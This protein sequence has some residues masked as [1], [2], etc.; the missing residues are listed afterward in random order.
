MDTPL[1]ANEDPAQAQP[2]RWSAVAGI[3]GFL[4]IVELTSGIL[5]GYY[6]PLMTDIARHLGIHDADVNWFEAAQLMVSALA[7]PLLAS[8]GDIFGHKKMLLLSAVV[9]AI[10][11]WAVVFS[12]SF[13]TFLIAWAFQG[14]YAVW[15]PLEIAIV[16]SRARKLGVPGPMTRR[17]AG[18]LVGALEF[19][20]IGGAL[21][22]GALIGVFDGNIA[23]TM[24]I[25][26]VATTACIFAVAFGVPDDGDRNGAKID[27]GGFAY[28]AIGL[29]LLTSGLSFLR[30]NG[31]SSPLVWACLVLGLVVLY[32]FYRH[33][34][35]Q[36]DPLIDFTVLFARSMWPV[37]LTAGLFGVSVLG[38]QIPMSTFA[39]TDPGV[40]G[41]GLGLSASGVSVIIGAYVLALLIGALLFPVAARWAGTRMTLVAASALVGIG[42]LLFLPL[43]DSLAQV[44]ANMMIAGIGSGALVAALP[45]A[46]AAAAPFNRT[47]MATGLTNAIK[48]VGGSFASAI[49]GL[50]LIGQV[51][52]AVSDGAGENFAAPLAGYMIV[53][54]ICGGTATV[55]ALALFA[56]P[57]DALEDVHHA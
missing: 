35:K 21:A 23:L 34:N 3:V 1:S 36:D 51:A 15:L 20:V 48:T 32:V 9:T 43:H 50:A 39:R 8:L 7:V 4:A 41:Y 37:Q 28:L 11:S 30:I 17:A 26:A 44:L 24:A 55:C 52:G 53:W 10:A 33:E 31:P 45:A 27:S 42:Y 12:G 16:F 57:R 56:V 18:L 22:G 54:A 46:A 25:P 2:V 14:F 40:N 19:G 38:A 13:T 5:Q 29:L 6:T 49:F 47:G